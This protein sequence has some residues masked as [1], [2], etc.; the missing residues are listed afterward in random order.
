MDREAL[1]APLVNL[2]CAEKVK[3]RSS[4]LNQPASPRA[5]VSSSRA[6]RVTLA[7]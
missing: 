6:L 4:L 5:L 7:C 2:K 3:D 1:K